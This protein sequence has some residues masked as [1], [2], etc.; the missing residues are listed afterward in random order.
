MKFLKNNKFI[1]GWAVLIVLCIVLII[2]QKFFNKKTEANMSD[3]KAAQY[4]LQANVQDGVIFYAWNWSYETIRNN[5]VDI[6]ASGYSAV[7]TSVVQE[8]KDYES[9]NLDITSQWRKMYEPVNFKI[10]KKSYLGKKEDLEELCDV[11]DNYGIKIIVEIEANKMASGEN[12]TSLNEKIKDEESQIYNDYGQYFHSYMEIDDTLKGVVQGNDG[13]PDLN[14][15]NAYIQKRVGDLMC[16][17]IDA[18]VDGFRFDSAGLIETSSDAYYGSSFFETVIGRAKNYAKNKNTRV[19]FYGAIATD[20]GNERFYSAYTKNLSITDNKTSDSILAAVVAGDADKAAA[21]AYYTGENPNKLLLWAESYETYADN[22]GSGGIA[23]TSVVSVK[24]INKAYAIVASRKGP[25]AIYFARPDENGVMG[26][27][28]DSE[29]M[30]DEVRAINKFHNVFYKNEEH[31][32]ASG[33]YV[34][35]ERYLKDSKKSGNNGAIIVGLDDNASKSVEITVS[36]LPDGKYNDMITGNVFEVKNGKITGKIGDSNIAVL[37]S[38]SMKNQINKKNVDSKT[39]E[40]KDTKTTETT[41][42]TKAEETMALED[43]KR[44]LYIDFNDCEWFN[45]EGTNAVIK[46]D[47]GEY[48]DMESFINDENKKIYYVIFDD[49]VKKCSIA[50]K[51]SASEVE[52]PY[53]L[54]LQNKYNMFKSLKKWGNGG[55][56]GNY[57]GSLPK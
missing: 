1:F 6:A 7:Q 15:S 29:W 17:C 42:E 20:I 4:G 21:S 26:N 33:K 22:K 52:K 25:A 24:N 36:K 23:D 10:A 30:S 8:P 31:I 57:E 9:D 5:L 11:A 43:G 56:W 47:D 45:E 49:T 39:K 2:V 41:E 19:Y 37:Y 27:S 54:T 12:S 40:T 18:G 13:A 55:T 50:R 44:I 14:T 38:D 35:N 3:E 53:T 16:D 28:G 32:S 34:I 46:L 48:E 51:N